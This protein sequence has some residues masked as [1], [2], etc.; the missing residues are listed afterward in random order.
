LDYGL[1]STVAYPDVLFFRA[2]Q[3][4]NPEVLQPAHP[5]HEKGVSAIQD[6]A[7]VKGGTR[8]RDSA[9]AKLFPQAQA[10]PEELTIQAVHDWVM[11]HRRRDKL[12]RH[13]V[14]PV[15]EVAT[16]RYQVHYVQT[17]QE[18]EV[19]LLFKGL[20]ANNSAVI[21]RLK[22]QSFTTVE[23]GAGVPTVLSSPETLRS[24]WRNRQTSQAVIAL[25]AIASQGAAQEEG[26]TL[27][28]ARTESLADVLGPVTAVAADAVFSALPAIPDL[29]ATTEADGVIVLATLPLETDCHQV[30]RVVTPEFNVDQF[31][32]Y[33]SQGNVDGSLE[34]LQAE[35]LGAVAFR[36]QTT[37]MIE[38]TAAVVDE[39]WTLHGDGPINLSVSIVTLQADGSLP[40]DEEIQRAEQQAFL[41]AERVK[42][43]L[44]LESRKVV[45]TPETL[46][47]CSV[48][49]L[50]V[51]EP[52]GYQVVGWVHTQE[53]LAT[54]NIGSEG[55]ALLFSF[56][57]NGELIP[58]ED[59]AHSLEQL[60]ARNVVFSR[61]ALAGLER[62]QASDPRLA[63]LC[64]ALQ[65]A[66]LITEET[67]RTTAKVRGEY[68]HI[69]RYG[70][71]YLSN[72]VLFGVD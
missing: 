26:T 1:I 11:F 44:S 67:R 32:E 16:R 46:A 57:P 21:A 52:A 51:T 34:E 14:P 62:P 66:G 60:K 53:N 45:F 72:V 55:E 61:I 28:E 27:A 33:V 58:D 23:F 8:F 4:P 56:R 7:R 13:D 41:I 47:P 40:P 50:L 38:S 63:S 31:Q 10:A 65:E 36:A 59:F 48:Y 5:A 18:S 70:E 25:G 22:P 12:C 64:A 69:M 35:P 42:N 17:R 49:T 30:Y 43:Q 15:A 54:G 68:S 29:F 3:K 2:L 9:M 39:A 20:L 6:I 37:E 19:K 71:R 24:L